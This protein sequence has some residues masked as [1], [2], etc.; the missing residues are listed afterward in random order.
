[1]M[2]KHVV[3]FE[4][5]V[6]KMVSFFCK[7]QSHKVTNSTGLFGMP[8]ALLHACLIKKTNYCRSQ[9]LIR[10]KKKTNVKMEKGDT[11]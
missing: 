6:I 9:P 4:M 11:R 2:L 10:G 5:E 1:M 7:H 3:A 8:T